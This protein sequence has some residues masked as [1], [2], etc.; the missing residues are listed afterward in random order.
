MNAV[1]L[2]NG[3]QDGLHHKDMY[4]EMLLQYVYIIL[5]VL[6]IIKKPNSGKEK[7]TACFVN[8]LHLL[9]LK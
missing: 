1:I 3:I 6:A 5:V 9:K 2:G 7:C 8:P 4:V